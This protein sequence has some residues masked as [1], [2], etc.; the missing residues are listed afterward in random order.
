MIEHDYSTIDRRLRRVLLFVVTVSFALT[1]IAAPDF[2]WQ[3]SRGRVVLSDLTPPGPLLTAGT[4]VA[5]AD[6]LGGLPFF[7]TLQIAGVSGLMLVKFLA[8]GLLAYGIMSHFETRLK[9]TAF[10]RRKHWLQSRRS[11]LY[12]QK[13]CVVP[14]W[15]VVSEW[16]QQ[17][18]I[19]FRNIC[20]NILITSPRSNALRDGAIGW[21]EGWPC[22]VP[23]WCCSWS[24]IKS[25]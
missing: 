25:W 3:L 23:V 21:H 19:S 8:A 18:M 11:Y 15:Y 20:R 1:P 2:W 13:I 12:W 9:W 6:W 17:S 5:E 10:T 24:G 16:K 14:D 22:S 4:N 7:L